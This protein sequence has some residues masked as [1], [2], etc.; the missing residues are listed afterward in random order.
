[1]TPATFLVLTSGNCGA[2]WFA[3]ALNLHPGIFA[4]CGAYHPI[5]SLFRYDLKKDGPAL[6]RASTQAHYRYGAHPQ[7]MAR[8]LAEYA[9]KG[10]TP[11]S[12]D[13]ARLP[14]YVLDELRSLPT[15]DAYPAVGSVHAF[16]LTRLA[17]CR[18]QDPALHTHADLVIA[19]MIRHPVPR[20]EAFTRAF[21]KYQ[22]DPPTEGDE[23]DASLPY[24]TYREAIRAWV[25]EHLDECRAL[26]RT[27]GIS[28]EDPRVMASLFVYRMGHVV[29][30]VAQELRA[31]SG[32]PALKMESLQ[33]DRAYF[34]RAVALLTAGR[35]EADDDYLDE[36]HRPE[37]LG[38][39]R[40]TAADGT[41][42]PDA[43]ATWEAWS[44]WER[45]EFRATCARD[46]IADIYAPHGYDFSF[47]H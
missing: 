39:G 43:R 21:E 34:A 3:S 26:E 20:T 37:H 22:I 28:M 1:M 29:T 30:W 46:A 18:R 4:G 17:E 8:L 31:F 38:V 41:R 32:V 24:V 2:I 33:E 47:L 19:N 14:W 13:Y 11:P 25:D 10:I 5:E 6:L 15:V 45:A 7:K 35:V 23:L 9:K 40:R 12:R 16:T 44:E 36:V 42:P 27:Y